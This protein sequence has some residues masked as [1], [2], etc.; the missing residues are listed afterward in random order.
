MENV[1]AEILLRSN[2]S[3]YL[4]LVCS[5]VIVWFRHRDRQTCACVRACARST[6]L[7]HATP[8][9]TQ[10]NRWSLVICYYLSAFCC[11]CFVGKYTKNSTS[12]CFEVLIF[13]T[14]LLGKDNLGTWRVFLLHH[15]ESPV[16]KLWIDSTVKQ[17][18][19]K[20]NVMLSKTF[21]PGLGVGGEGVV[22]Q[23]NEN[24]KWFPYL[25]NKVGLCVCVCVFRGKGWWW[26]LKRLTQN[27]S[28]F[29]I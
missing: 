20:A 24:R 6:L 10:E 26:S 5:L 21:M 19:T 27:V 7:F 9:I 22:N 14:A 16:L 29:P 12:I 1:A 17:K 28:K 13:L 2:I 15:T 25:Q 8:L 11:C 18:T 23:L 3:F 4:W